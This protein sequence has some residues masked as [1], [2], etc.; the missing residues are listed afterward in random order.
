MIS[1]NNHSQ[2]HYVMI[3]YMISCS[4]TWRFQMIGCTPIRI[5]ISGIIEISADIGVNI[6]IYRDRRTIRRYRCLVRI[7][8][9]RCQCTAAL[10][11]PVPVPGRPGV[12]GWPSS[13]RLP[14]PLRVRVGLSRHLESPPP[15]PNAVYR[16]IYIDILSCT[17]LGVL[18]LCYGTGRT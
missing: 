17:I 8:M 9:S 15:D 18:V 4:A 10:Q 2:Y 11:P 6:E 14:S 5:M 16:S 3:L 12:P 7:Q 13:L 1:Y